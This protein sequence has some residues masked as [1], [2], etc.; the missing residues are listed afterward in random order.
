MSYKEFPYV[1]FMLTTLSCDVIMKILKHKGWSVE[2]WLVLNEGIMVFDVQK[3]LEVF[4]FRPFII[5]YWY[6]K[7]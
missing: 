4:H 1:I 6:F 2:A 7:A 3:L 5:Y